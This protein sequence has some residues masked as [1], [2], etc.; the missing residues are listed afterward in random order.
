MSANEF[1]FGVGP[2]DKI[3]T[4]LRRNQQ[5]IG[6]EMEILEWLAT[7]DNVSRLGEVIRGF[8][9]IKPLEFAID[10][11][12]TPVIPDGL[13]IEKHLKGGIIR[14]TK[15]LVRLH[16]T[17]KQKKGLI[18]GH[19]LRKELED[20]KVLNACVLDFLLKNPHLIPEE[21]K[22][23]AVFFWGTIYRDAGGNLYVRCLYWRGSGWG[24]G[25]G[26]LDDGWDE[27]SPAAVRSK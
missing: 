6:H 17:K 21:W 3:Q 12:A 9:E 15:D 25:Y 20:E 7:G 1:V 8:S 18:G 23:K 27:G 14:W 16:L 10:C 24:W 19:E 26:W 2:A 13:T 22:G 4:A 11:D 5:V